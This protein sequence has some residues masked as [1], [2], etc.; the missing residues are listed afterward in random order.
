[1]SK[2]K[3]SK[4]KNTGIIFELL[5]R[6]ITEETMADGS[7]TA[8]SLMKKH[9][10][11][12]SNL[13]KEYQIYR[14][15]TQQKYDDKMT[16]QMFIETC[17]EKYNGINKS[18]LRRE[19][20]NLVKEIKSVYNTETFFNSKINNYR[21]LA[22]IYIM[23][24]NNGSPSLITN[25]KLSIIESIV[26]PPTVSTT[27]STDAITET[28]SQMSDLD[29][30]LTYKILIEKFNS[31]YS[32]LNSEQKSLL[33]EYIESVTNTPRLKQ[34]INESIE[35]VQAELDVM[36]EKVT[37]PVVKIKINEVRNLI[38]P[39]CKKSSVHDDNVVNLLNYYELVQELRNIHG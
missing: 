7:T 21:N 13:L 1:M 16:A 10:H 8:V 35:K 5:V 24:E 25:T 37:N 15:I 26:T 18:H 33:R 31:K 27:E 19:K 3:H 9:F 20:Y 38:K 4:Y 23:L 34:Y 12:N 28:Y 11:K 17:V 39:L 22:S 30:K 36:V 2:V 29:K 14:S 6:Q 32:T